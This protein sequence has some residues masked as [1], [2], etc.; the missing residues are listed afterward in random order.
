MAKV[1]ECIVH[2]WLYGSLQ[3]NSI[4]HLTVRFIAQHSTQDVLVSMVDGWRKA[5]YVNI[6]LSWMDVDEQRNS[7]ITK[8]ILKYSTIR[9]AG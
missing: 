6:Y 2:Q 9:L 1:F 3:E 4:L 8:I 5:W 7:R